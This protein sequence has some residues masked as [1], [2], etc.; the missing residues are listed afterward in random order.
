MKNLSKAILTGTRDSRLS[1]AQ[2]R[3]AIERLCGIFPS[4]KF[5]LV[6]MS[7]P[8]DRDKATDLRLTPGDFFTRDLDDALREGRVDLAVHSAKDLPDPV[9]ADLDWFRSVRDQ[10]AAAGTA[11]YLKQM[12]IRGRVVVEPELDSRTHTELAWKEGK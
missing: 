10:C 6:S 12:S 2:T 5:E 7:S 9:P 3:Q 1:L 4:L 8:G 11:F